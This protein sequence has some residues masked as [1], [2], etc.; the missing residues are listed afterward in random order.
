MTGQQLKDLRT[1]KGWDQAKTADELGVS[2]HTVRSWEQDKNP[3]PQTVEKLL[4]SE[5]DLKIPLDLILSVNKVATERSISFDE[6][7]FDAI[8]KGIAK[9]EESPKTP[10]SAAKRGGKGGK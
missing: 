7:L 2:I 8:R 4:L 1:Q 10:G 3:I 6:A 5:V 9:S